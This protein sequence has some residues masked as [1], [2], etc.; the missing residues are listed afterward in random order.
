MNTHPIFPFISWINILAVINNAAM[1][2]HAQVCENMFSVLLYTYILRS[3]IMELF[4][5]LCLT[6]FLRNCQT[7]FCS[8]YTTLHSYW[9]CMRLPVSPHIQQHFSFNF[10]IFFTAIVVVA[11]WYLTVLICISLIANMLSI[12]CI[13]AS[14]M[15]SLEICL[16]K[17]CVHFKVKLDCFLF[18]SFSL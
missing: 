16:L 18:L 5:T 11:K 12:L 17:F 14:C 1:N 6:L 4:I 3:G 13:L 7:V 9:Q 8:G 2:I 10:I 15:S